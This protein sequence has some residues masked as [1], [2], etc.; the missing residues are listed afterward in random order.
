MTI[1]ANLALECVARRPLSGALVLW[2]PLLDGP[3]YARSLALLQNRF[4]ASL[5]AAPAAPGLAAGSFECL[6]QAWPD[7]LLDQ[8]RAW[9]APH[10]AQAPAPR[11]LILEARPSPAGVDLARELERSGARVVHEAS[12]GSEPWNEDIDRGL[13]PAA[14]LQRIAGFLRE[15]G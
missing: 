9:R 4:V 3:A 5:P 10:F 13:V 12:S 6:G 7:G 11:A 15:A 2:E 8:L 1:S 14:D